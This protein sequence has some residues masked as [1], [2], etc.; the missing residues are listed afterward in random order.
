[1]NQTGTNQLTSLASVRLVCRQYNAKSQY[2]VHTRVQFIGHPFFVNS[3]PSIPVTISE[4]EMQSCF[5]L[6]L[7]QLFSVVF[8][9]V[10]GAHKF[11]VRLVTKDTP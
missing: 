2:C 6:E 3:K 5:L 11:Y 4:A 7:R 9:V 8:C 10:T 1:M